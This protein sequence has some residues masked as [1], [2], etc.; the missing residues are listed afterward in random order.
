MT[1]WKTAWWTGPPLDEVGHVAA[2]VSGASFF[3]ILRHFFFYKRQNDAPCRA[4]HFGR[5]R[6][7]T[8]V[9]HELSRCTD[10]LDTP[11]VVV[12]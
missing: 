6:G 10:V 12:R 4:F 9:R 8:Q 2:L 7:A 3:L 1:G 5:K 11:S